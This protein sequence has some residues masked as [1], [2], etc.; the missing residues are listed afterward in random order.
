MNTIWDNLEQSMKII[1]LHPFLGKG[2]DNNSRLLM[3]EFGEENV[4]APDLPIDPSVVEPM[5]DSIISKVGAANTI[6]VGASLGGFWAH[7]LAHKHNI[8]CVIVNASVSPSLTTDDIVTGD[9]EIDAQISSL[10]SFSSEFKNREV[11]IQNNYNEKLLYMFFAKNDKINGFAHSITVLP[12]SA[13]CTITES[14][15]HTFKGNWQMVVDVVR[16]LF[17]SD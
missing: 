17:R 7:Y 5:L 2:L 12:K 14:G 10:V 8:R 9:A 13:L 11:F 4:I 6:L 3:Q 16:S 15:G 1:Y